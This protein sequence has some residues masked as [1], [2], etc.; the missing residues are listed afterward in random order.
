MINKKRF[1]S[2]CFGV[3]KPWDGL[4]SIT[5]GTTVG[6]GQ[7]GLQEDVLALSIRPSGD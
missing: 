5:A 6:V 2:N 7:R 4:R 3:S 1:G